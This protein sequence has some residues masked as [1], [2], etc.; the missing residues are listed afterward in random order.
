MIISYIPI[1]IYVYDIHILF[2]ITDSIYSLL[3]LYRFFFLFLHFILKVLFVHPH[4]RII[5]ILQESAAACCGAI[6][7]RQI[8]NHTQGLIWT[9]Q[10]KCRLWTVGGERENVQTHTQ[11][12][13]WSDS[14][15]LHHPMQRQMVIKWSF[16]INQSGMIHL[17]QLLK[18]LIKMYN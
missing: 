16:K 6:T 2:K 8:T 3:E 18:L 9:H 12:W 7:Q 5:Q 17:F 1:R 13:L 14:A 15:N 4:Y 11:V 10:S